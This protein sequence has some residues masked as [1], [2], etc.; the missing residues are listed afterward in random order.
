M[1]IDR[2][3]C[4]VQAP[5]A[6]GINNQLML[7]EHVPRTVRPLRDS[8]DTNPELPLPKGSVE[9]GQDWISSCTDHERVEFGVQLNEPGGVVLSFVLLV[10]D[11]LERVDLPI[12]HAVQC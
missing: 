6:Q 11:A 2:L 5:A 8:A 1:G 4:G 7:A 10:D 9:I 3:M 12:R